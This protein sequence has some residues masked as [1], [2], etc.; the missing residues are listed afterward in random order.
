MT[1]Y[2][3]KYK[4]S[5]YRT[6]L[7]ETEFFPTVILRRCY[8][9]IVIIRYLHASTI[10]VVINIKVWFLQNTWLFMLFF[11]KKFK[12]IFIYR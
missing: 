2:I 6:N 3:S 12:F 10:G 5:K 9:I 4:F 11:A 1:N 8:Y 7:I